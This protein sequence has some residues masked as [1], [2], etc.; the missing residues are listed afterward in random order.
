MHQKH[1]FLFREGLWKA[2]GFYVDESGEQTRAVGET[3]IT[4]DKNHWYN[5]GFMKM[6]TR[7]GEIT[8]NSSYSILPLKK[9]QDST[10]WISENQALGRVVGKFT[11]VGD[12]IISLFGTGNRRY[13]G[14]ECLVM[15][16]PDTYINRGCLYRGSLKVSSWCVELKKAQE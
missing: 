15:T 13:K 3:R 10:S 9:G 11:V 8:L 4:H 1:T 5:E 14:S 6:K 7:S 2:D 12:T 16:G